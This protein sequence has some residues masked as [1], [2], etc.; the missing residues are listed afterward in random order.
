M[1]IGKRRRRHPVS[2]AVSVVGSGFTPA[3]LTGLKGWWSA[4][5]AGNTNPGGN[6]TTVAVDQSGVGNNWLAT[7]VPY[8]PTGSSNGSPAWEFVNSGSDFFSFSGFNLDMTGG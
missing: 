2:H 6:T 4:D 3:S 8:N 1:F 7:A 5:Y